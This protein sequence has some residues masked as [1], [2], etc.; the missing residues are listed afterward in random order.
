MLKDCSPVIKRITYL[1]FY[2]LALVLNFEY[3]L[4]VGIGLCDFDSI[5]NLV[6]RLE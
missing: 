1:A 5:H 6:D 2:S 3:I 4:R